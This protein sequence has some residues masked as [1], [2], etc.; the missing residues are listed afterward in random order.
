VRSVPGVGCEYSASRSTVQ[1]GVQYEYSRE[2]KEYGEYA[3]DRVQG[4]MY[5]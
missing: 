5:L 1:V 3:V 2:Q 4:V